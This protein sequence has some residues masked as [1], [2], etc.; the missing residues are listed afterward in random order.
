MR[1]RAPCF[2]NIKGLTH[3]AAERL[4]I[5]LLFATNRRVPY[6]LTML[7]QGVTHMLAVS[8]SHF[9][10]LQP[11]NI[12]SDL[13]SETIFYFFNNTIYEVIRVAELSVGLRQTRFSSISF[14]PI[15]QQIFTFIVLTLLFLIITEIIFISYNKT[16]YKYNSIGTVIVH[17][18]EPF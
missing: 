13:C 14:K 4:N 18:L 7:A 15:I 16:S 17:C 10:K 11:N 2:L 9:P 8:L 5:Y 3:T 12:L 1:G 6:S